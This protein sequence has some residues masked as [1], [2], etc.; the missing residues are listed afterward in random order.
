MK[1]SIVSKLESLLKGIKDRLMTMRVALTDKQ[2]VTIISAY[3]PTMSNP[4]E[5]KDKFYEDL[6]HVISAVPKRNKLFVMCE[7]NAGSA[8]WEGFD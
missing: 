6:D 4:D 2:N 3:A 8:L 1:T 5:I 7:F